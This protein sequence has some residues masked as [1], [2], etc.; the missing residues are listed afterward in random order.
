MGIRDEFHQKAIMAGVQELCSGKP[1]VTNTNKD[2]G[3]QCNPDFMDT[4]RVTQYSFPQLE[5]CD[6]CHKYLRGLH[7]QGM[8]CQDCNIVSHRSC[9]ANGLTPLCTHMNQRGNGQTIYHK[10]LFGASLCS[11]FNVRE[12]PAPQILTL[13]CEELERQAKIT[14]LDLYKLY[15]TS[16]SADL[17]NSLRNKMD[18]DPNTVKLCDYSP[19]CIVSVM[20]KYLRELPDP[21]IPVQLYDYFILAARKLCVSIV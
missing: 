5:K 12:R 15:Q 11:V 16:S 6:K 21:V 18:L 2:H 3:Q 8:I 19:Q 17:V 10:S 9:T 13:L 1:I 7:H 20:K 4:H 14:K